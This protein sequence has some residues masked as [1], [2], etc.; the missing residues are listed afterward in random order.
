MRYPHLLAAFNSTPWAILPEKLDEIRA[1]LEIKVAGGDVPEERV[2]AIEAG[3]RDGSVQMA[4]RVAVMPVFGVIAQ[5]VGGVERMSGMIGTEE[6]GATLDSL[7]EDKQVRAIVMAFDSPGGSVF[8]VPELADKIRAARDKKKIVA[9]ADSLAASAAYWLAAQ[10]SEVVVTPGGQIGSVGVIA[11]HIDVSKAEELKGVKTTLVTSSPY[12]AEFAPE[13]PLSEE[14]RGELQ[15]KVNHY[16]GLF[17][18]ALAKGRG[19]TEAA[20]AKNFGQGRMLTAKAAVEAGMADRVG[21]LAQVLSRLDPGAG[22]ASAA[23]AKARARAV[24]LEESV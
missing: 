15:A 10:A 2:E 6:I 21:T 20:V 13:S 3:R 22:G 7:V 17:V 11:A 1:F 14:A 23:L 4:G 19:A 9:L 5:R 12:K 8:G 16:H 18:G 24:S